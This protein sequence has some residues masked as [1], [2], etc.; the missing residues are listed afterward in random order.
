MNPCLSPRAQGPQPG[1]F[2]GLASLAFA[3]TL[4]AACGGGGSASPTPVTPSA[5][6]PPP[7]P[8]LTRDVIVSAYGGSTTQPSYSIGNQRQDRIDLFGADNASGDFIA[9]QAA[10]KVVGE[11]GTQNTYSVFFDQNG[12][13]TRINDESNRRYVL[14][15]RANDVTRFE[16]Y[17]SSNRFQSGF[18][19]VRNGSG[20]QSVAMIKG[21]P[22]VQSQQITG[23]LQGGIN[24]SFAVVSEQNAGLDTPQDLPAPMRNYL[25]VP[26]SAARSGR[27]QP[28]ATGSAAPASI[29]SGLETLIRTAAETYPIAGGVAGGLLLAGSPLAIPVAQVAL[30]GFGVAL[31]ANTVRQAL[32]SQRDQI[33]AGDQR[34][35]YDSIFGTVSEPSPSATS[36]ISRLIDEATRQAGSII[37]SGTAKLDQLADNFRSRSGVA[38][39]TLQGYLDPTQQ[40]APVSGPPVVDTA[41]SGSGVD[42]NNVQYR[43]RG[44]LANG[45]NLHLVATPTAGSTP[46]ITLDGTL[47]ANQRVSG[48]YTDGS[49]TGSF[50]GS[51][52]PLGQCQTLTQSGGQG[53]FSYASDVGSASGTV[54]FSYNAYSIPDAFTVTNADQTVFTTNGLVSGTGGNSFPI[55]ASTVFVTVSAPNNGTAWDFV[56]GC[57]S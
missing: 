47:D 46:P 13:P 36:L 54:S 53:T 40:P 22:V 39:D 21:V 15:K 25:A 57:A 7:V 32:N 8:T 50:S 48:S 29:S 26:A 33:P 35:M 27:S 16:M 30:V 11:S 45:G 10:V 56:L 12:A 6:P 49:N 17:D 4:L 51:A 43:Y 55:S 5:P 9:N 18:A 2:L 14:V 20:P 28:A 23:Q 34:D 24:G 3:S 1:R 44:T 31:A 41:V 19:I 52:A 42:S 37:Q 38:A